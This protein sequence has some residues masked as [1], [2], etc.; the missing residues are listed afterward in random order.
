[1]SA[2]AD[3]RR[4]SGKRSTS[5][6]RGRAAT[7]R[8]AEP[9]RP[10]ALTRRGD[11][12]QAAAAAA[13]DPHGTAERRR[14]SRSLWMACET[15]LS[16]GEP[17]ALHRALDALRAAFDCDGVAL[18]ALAPGGALEPWC[19]RGDWRA[20]AGDL[21]GCMSVPLFRG[22]ERVGTLDLRAR[23]GERWRPTQL[24]LIRTASGALG[25][26]LGARLEL[27]RLRNQPGRDSVTGLPDARAFH[28]RVGEGLARAQRA[29]TAIAVVMIDL[30]HFGAL[31]ARHGKTV[32]DAVLSEAALVLKL[33]LRESDVIARLGGDA[34]GVLL[35]DT[36]ALPALRCA[37]RL[38]RAVEEHRFARV[39]HLT[40]SAGVA[41][42][43]RDGMEGVEL[44]DA[45]DR[46][47]G[48]AKKSGRRRA[49]VAP[50]A[51]TH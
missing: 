15:L 48:V 10:H 24:G 30:D 25:A 38:R 17:R 19:A 14:A 22:P 39:G 44:L 31:N 46:A 11:A 20:A 18:Y 41:S 51:H 35:D 27:E 5:K 40:L 9:H 21:R 2:G 8:A 36:D 6:T 33:G 43:P 28:E 37:E 4:G 34:F 23:A 13:A 49:V 42:S 45:A 1:M 29:G 47:L 16:A 26:A 12:T 50:S 7:P 3:V 32:G